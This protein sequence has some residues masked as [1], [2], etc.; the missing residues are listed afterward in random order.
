MNRVQISCDIVRLPGKF[1]T[2]YCK[3]KKNFLTT[4]LRALRLSLSIWLLLFGMWQSVDLFFSFIFFKQLFLSFFFKSLKKKV[5]ARSTKFGIL[6]IRLATFSKPFDTARST[7]LRLMKWKL[8]HPC[9]RKDKSQGT[10]FFAPSYGSE[11]TGE[12]AGERKTV[13]CLDVF[14]FY[15]QTQGCVRLEL[16]RLRGRWREKR[17]REKRNCSK[18][19]TEHSAENR[20]KIKQHQKET[21]TSR[22]LPSYISS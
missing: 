9:F 21:S 2:L 1:V 15:T 6:Y 16:P 5:T 3:K 4:R 14:F 8:N 7:R 10:S 20:Q 17:E 18:T 22:A 13:A 11:E 19:V 12:K